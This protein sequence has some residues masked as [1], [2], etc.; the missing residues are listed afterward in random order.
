[1]SSKQEQNLE[2]YFNDH[3]LG[4][5]VNAADGQEPGVNEKLSLDTPYKPNLLDLYR[6]HRFII[7]NKRTTVLEFGVG[8]S[9]L[10]FAHAMS[11]NKEKYTN[12]VKNLRRNNP[13]EVHSVDSEPRFIKVASDRIPGNLTTCVTFTS[14]PIRMTS[15]QGRY[16]TEYHHLPL[17]NPD[18][19]Y[20]DGPDQFNL[21]NDINGFTTA[22]KDMMPMSC[23]ILKI[24]HFLTP[25]TM[26]VVDGRAANA[27]FLQANM[28]RNWDY[29]YSADADQHIFVLNEEPLGKYNRQQ[30]DFYRGKN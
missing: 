10:V 21:T 20:L 24:E 29:T 9:T 3:G 11:L 15:F 13:F 17:V 16:A 5:I 14:S 4:F 7:D 2:K 22:H 19:I 6:L 27:R 8:W 23:D 28:Q 1:M 18:F 26:I 30:L 25:G 12:D